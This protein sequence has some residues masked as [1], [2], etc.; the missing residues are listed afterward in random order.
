M[1]G[2]IGTTA[3]NIRAPVASN[4]I[5]YGNQYNLSQLYDDVIGGGLGALGGKLGEDVAR[6]VAKEVAGTFAT[7]AV[8]V[9][10]AAGKSPKLVAEAGR[11][12]AAATEARLSLRALAE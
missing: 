9:A 4:M 1:A 5:I 3:L 8:R 10:E 11:A 2:F 7:E 6:L 12:A